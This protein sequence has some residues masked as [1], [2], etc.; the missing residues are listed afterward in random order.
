[1]D[2]AMIVSELLDTLSRRSLDSDESYDTF[3]EMVHGRLSDVEIAAILAALKTRGETPAVLAGAARALRDAAVPFPKPDYPIADTCGT[4]GDGANTINVSTAAAFVAA[5]GGVKVAKHGN[6]ATSSSCGSA[7]LLELLGVRLDPPPAVGRR[8]LDEAGVCFLFAPAYHPGVRAATGV[9]RALRTRTAFNLLGPLANPAHPEFQVMGI[10]AP[11]L[12]R[13][14][15]ETLRLLGCR[16]ALVVNGNGLDEIA[17]HGETTAAFLHEGVVDDVT[18]TP[19]DA[20]LARSPIESLGSGPPETA[21]AWLRGLLGGRGE[22]AHIDAVA[23]N[24]GAMFWIAGLASSLAAGTD[25][26]LDILA[27]DRALTHLDLLV[28][29]SHGN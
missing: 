9:R 5:A 16:S 25:T 27:S 14:A 10:Y 15:A 4:G 19:E 26:A 24:A 23:L 22:R 28:E 17:L 2:G 7:D 6:R 18:F 1:V 21:G 8:C 13:P 3:A 12:V 29:L 20:G 11:H